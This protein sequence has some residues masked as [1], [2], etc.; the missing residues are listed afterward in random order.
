MAGSGGGLMLYT[1][2]DPST[3][4]KAYGDNYALFGG[5]GSSQ[6]PQLSVT[7]EI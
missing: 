5:V 3:Y 6:T 2:S 4:G 1:A 7:Y